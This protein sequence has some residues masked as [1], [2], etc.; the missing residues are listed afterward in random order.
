[1]SAQKKADSKIDRMARVLDGYFDLEE[2]MQATGEPAEKIIACLNF[3]RLD[4]LLKSGIDPKSDIMKLAR[5]RRDEVE[6]DI[7]EQEEDLDELIGLYS[8]YVRMIPEPLA[9]CNAIIIRIEQ[10]VSREIRDG[11]RLILSRDEYEELK[12]VEDTILQKAVKLAYERWRRYAHE[13]LEAAKT[14]L[15]AS[16]VLRNIPDITSLRKRAESKLRRLIRLE[17]PQIRELYM[18]ERFVDDDVVNASPALNR[19]IIKKWKQ[20]AF[21]KVDKARTLDALR[22]L[23]VD[24]PDEVKPIAREKMSQIA[25]RKLKRLSKF[26][27][28]KDLFRTV[29]GDGK[30]DDDVVKA[31]EKKLEAKALT[32][33]KQAST[34]EDLRLVVVYSEKGSEARQIALRRMYEMI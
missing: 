2:V 1:M 5:A 23:W 12:K 20:L 9:V 8:H 18:I 14:V 22:I 13:E 32:L 34:V 19:Y 24:L 27:D 11:D 33:A 21:E 3:T 10:V 26:A 7:I 29:Y 6:I 15:D 25:M 16:C 17:V 30:V 28:F 31:I 4:Q